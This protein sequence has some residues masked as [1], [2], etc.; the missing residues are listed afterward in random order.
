MLIVN[1]ARGPMA[2]INC[3]RLVPPGWGQVHSFDRPQRSIRR[4]VNR[5]ACLDQQRLAIDG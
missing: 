1:S 5:A 4:C 3:E 2:R